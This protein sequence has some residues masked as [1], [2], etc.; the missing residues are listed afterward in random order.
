MKP[1][2]APCRPQLHCGFKLMSALAKK[3]VILRR[4]FLVLDMSVVFQQWVCN[5]CVSFQFGLALWDC[6][7]NWRQVFYWNKIVSLNKSALLSLA[8]AWFVLISVISKGLL[9][10]WCSWNPGSMRDRKELTSSL[11]I[12]CLRALSQFLFLTAQ[13]S[14]FPPRFSDKEVEVLRV[15]HVP[16]V[17]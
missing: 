7:G 4:N 8:L 17:T 11:G 14:S 2:C 13:W 9:K 1:H 3:Q 5:C 16:K 15:L 12:R 10:R 6:R